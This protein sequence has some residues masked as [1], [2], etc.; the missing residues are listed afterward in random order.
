MV[1]GIV[2][3][4]GAGQDKLGDGQKG[5]AILEQSLQNGRQSFRGVERGA[6]E[7]HDTLSQTA[8]SRWGAGDS[9]ILNAR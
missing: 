9:V 7:E 1:N 6:A 8:S 2:G 5:I 3:A 4:A